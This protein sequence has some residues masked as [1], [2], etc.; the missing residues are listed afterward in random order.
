MRAPVSNF[1]AK[2][3][4]TREKL[5]ADSQLIKQNYQEKPFYHPNNNCKSPQNKKY[6]KNTKTGRK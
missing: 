4:K 3:C 6:A 1:I 5:S 2:D